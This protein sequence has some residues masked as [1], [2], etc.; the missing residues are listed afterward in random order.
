MVLVREFLEIEKIRMGSRLQLT[1][2]SGSLST[3]TSQAHQGRR[4]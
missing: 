3:L 1:R 4:F 2:D